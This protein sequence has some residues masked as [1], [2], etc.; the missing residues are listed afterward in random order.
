MNLPERLY[1]PLHEA[2]EKLGC[3]I[4]D[5]IHFG[6]TGALNISI[7]IRQWIETEESKFV[8]VYDALNV[9]ADQGSSGD[10]KSI[11]GD[12][13][14]V[15]GIYKKILPEDD[16]AQSATFAKWFGGFFYISPSDLVDF[17]FNYDSEVITIHFLDTHCSEY[18]DGSI[19]LNNIKGIEIPARYICIMEDDI[20]SI[21]H[22][23]EMPQPLEQ[24]SVKRKPNHN[25]QSQFI[26]A[27]IEI[28]YGITQ[29]DNVYE[30]MKEGSKHTPLGRMRED[31]ENVGFRLPA[32]HKTVQLWLDG[33]DLD[34]LEISKSPMEISKK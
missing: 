34:P 11:E 30:L 20:N 19:Q 27:L 32:G 23:G 21:N 18:F 2:A 24:T 17:E 22:S 29:S 28:H 12:S 5:V 14:G 8:V 33:V 13:W 6:A 25:K 1:Y 3:Q 15:H 9:D 7:Y 10:F 31:F 16:I 4:K 26:K